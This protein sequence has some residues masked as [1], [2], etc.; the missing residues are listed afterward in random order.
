MNVMTPIFRVS[1]PNVFKARRNE[2][3]GKD[4]FSLVALFPKGCDLAVLKQA[5]QKA[6]EEKW[7]ADKSKHPKNIR[8][9]FRDQGE[10]KNDKGMPAGYEDGAIFLNLKSAQRPGLINGRKEDIIDESEFYAGCWARAT[11]SVYAYDQAGNRGVAFGLGNLQKVKE[12][13]PLSGRA[14]AQ[15]E[16]AAVEDAGLEGKDSTSLFS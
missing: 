1:Y 15:D 9:P 8:S 5:A 7:G 2:L 16:F 14:K 11:V 10:R 3:S 6:I 4:E 12:G 13:D